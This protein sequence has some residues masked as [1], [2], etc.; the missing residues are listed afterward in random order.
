MHPILGPEYADTHRRTILLAEKLG[1]STVIDF[2]GCP[3]DSENAKYP[4]FVTVAWLPGY[5][6]ILQWQW[7][8]KVIPSWRER[9]QFARDHITRTG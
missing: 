3:G 8:Q 5:P 6:E 9:A 2:S 4:N 7:E 1:V